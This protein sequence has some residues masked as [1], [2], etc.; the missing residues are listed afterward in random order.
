MEKKVKSSGRKGRKKNILSKLE[1]AVVEKLKKQI[2]VCL[3]YRID[4]GVPITPMNA[5]KDLKPEE[6][7]ELK[8]QIAALL[9]YSASGG[10]PIK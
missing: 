10:V 1:P 8:A 2:A 6:V 5:L 7:E 3:N 9:N 4:G